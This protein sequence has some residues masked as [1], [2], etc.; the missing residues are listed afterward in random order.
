MLHFLLEGDPDSPSSID[1]LSAKGGA[2]NIF[3]ALRPY[4]K[5]GAP[6]F[7]EPATRF[8]R[9]GLPE[10]ILSSDDLLKAAQPYLSA[11]KL[12]P[13]PFGPVHLWAILVVPNG[14]YDG[15]ERA[16]YLADDLTRP[17][18]R[19]LLR[20]AL[21]QELKRKRG[22]DLSLPPDSVTQ[23]LGTAREMQSIDPDPEHLGAV[24]GLRQLRVLGVRR[25]SLCH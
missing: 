4:L 21:D 22:E 8:F 24:T 16:T 25:H 1:A 19:D 7:I 17:F 6:R 2:I 10:E 9:V 13:G 18:L 15:S 5:T 11:E 20:A 23:L 3:I 14:F 12:I